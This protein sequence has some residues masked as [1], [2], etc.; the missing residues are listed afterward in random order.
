MGPLFSEETLIGLAYDF[1][2]RTLAQQK[3]APYILPA[4]E[5]A[6]VISVQIQEGQKPQAGGYMFQLYGKRK[7]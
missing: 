4:T 1:E 7:M 3:G 5:L 2:Q 6:D